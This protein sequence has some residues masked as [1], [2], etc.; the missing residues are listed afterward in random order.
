M[1]WPQR[2]VA[3]FGMQIG[4][5]DLALNRENRLHLDSDNGSMIGMINSEDL[6]IPEFIVFISRP[7]VYISSANLKTA[8]QKCQYI[9]FSNWPLQI[10]CTEKNVIFA[11]RIPQRS[12]S[13]SVLNEVLKLLKQHTAE[14]FE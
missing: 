6:T 1:D 10:A 4:I 3:E 11:I 5:P 9:N 2:I 8:L 7:T 13:L 14:F 12:L